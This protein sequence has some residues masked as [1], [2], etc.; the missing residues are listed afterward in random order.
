MPVQ[1][2]SERA[3]EN[4]L[5]DPELNPLLNPLLAAHMGRW[6]EVYFTNPPEKRGEAVAQLLRELKSISPPEPAPAPVISDARER[7]S[8]NEHEAETVAT[9][10][11]PHPAATS[12]VR[13]CQVCGYHNAPEQN[14]CG[15]CGVPLQVIPEAPAL[16]VAEVEP[17]AA[18]SWC[19]RSLGDYPVMESIDVAAASGAANGRHDSTPATQLE[20]EE[21]VP[22]FALEPEPA[23]NRYRVYAGIGL[24]I[25]LSALVYMAWR[26]TQVLSGSTVPQATPARTVPSA[27]P[28]AAI[29]A[30][31]ASASTPIPTTSVPPAAASARTQSPPVVSSPKDQAADVQPG[32]RIVPVTASSSTQIPE[33]SGAEEL[34]IAEKFLNGNQGTPRDSAEAALWLWKAV[35]KGNLTAT[36]SLSDMY[37]RGDG[38]AKSCDQARVLLDAAARKGGKAAAER[39]R[40]LQAFGCE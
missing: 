35:G 4:T 13:T 25:L 10:Q 29:S 27:E 40:N 11:A 8:E 23:S 9:A 1:P 26:G 7:E 28:A 17:I 21:Y 39:L 15:M 19:E 6:A 32:P 3:D 14:F 22:G 38:V 33:Q 30:P 37:L 20:L 5:P 12:T 24:A 18:G 31:Q 34:A 2:A 36:I 16:P